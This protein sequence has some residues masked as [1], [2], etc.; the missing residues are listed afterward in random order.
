MATRK[1]TPRMRGFW[2]KEFWG[3]VLGFRVLGF[4]LCWLFC[5]LALRLRGRGAEVVRGE[6]GCMAEWLDCWCVL[7]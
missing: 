4:G 5:V 1:R 3:W 7:V 6:L 2:F